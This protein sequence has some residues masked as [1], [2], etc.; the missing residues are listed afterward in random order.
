MGLMEYCKK[1]LAKKESKKTAV[2]RKIAEFRGLNKDCTAKEVIEKFRQNTNLSN[3]ETSGLSNILVQK[4]D[5]FKF[6]LLRKDFDAGAEIL[7]KV[8]NASECFHVYKRYLL[9]SGK[10]INSIELERIVQQRLKHSEDV[11]KIILNALESAKTG[12][13][14]WIPY[15]DRNH[16]PS[17]GE[18]YE[19]TMYDTYDKDFKEP[20]IRTT[21]YLGNGIWG[22]P[23]GMK[24][25]AYKELFPYVPTKN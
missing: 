8:H 12:A 20:Y 9:D 5:S 24:V 22:V 2:K 13:I 7:S 4:G 6:E 3:A 19:V 11:R 17:R 23:R 16:I 10:Y 25:V 15:P 21:E 18:W 1:H 14:F